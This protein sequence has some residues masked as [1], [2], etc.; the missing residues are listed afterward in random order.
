VASCRSVRA[1][2]I[3]LGTWVAFIPKESVRRPPLRSSKTHHQC[4]MG[5]G[6][7]KSCTLVTGNGSALSSVLI[8]HVT[9]RVEGE[10]YLPLYR[11]YIS[12]SCDHC[13]PP[14]PWVM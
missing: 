6:G 10:L 9:E 14:Y 3:L 4:L 1:L 13:L 7:P 11:S 12:G 2:H 8:G 5:G